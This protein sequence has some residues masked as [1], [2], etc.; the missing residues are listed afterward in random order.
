MADSHTAFFYG[1]L[2]HP[3]VLK[4]VI[5]NDGAHLELCP[6]V[7]LEHTRHEVK[8]CE[9]PGVIPI[10][11]GLKIL[12]RSLTQEERSV[13]GTL[14]KGLTAQD[15]DFLDAFESDEYIRRKVQVHPLGPFT[16]VSAETVDGDLVPENPPALPEISKLLELAVD[17]ETYIYCDET[18]LNSDLWSFKDF[19]KNNAWKW[20]GGT[21]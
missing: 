1:T 8:L 15:M 10:S 2:M 20:Y 18:N 9:Y 16:K 4:S 12:N 5:H 17:A 13:R 7:L 19:V 3:K 11:K 6:A 21:R 14:V